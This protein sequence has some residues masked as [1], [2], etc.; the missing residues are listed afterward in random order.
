[1]TEFASSSI[2]TIFTASIATLWGDLTAVIPS[3]VIVGVGV[4]VL[5]AVI[6]FVIKA[7]RHIVNG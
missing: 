5:S 6:W 7:P 2:N 3:Y 1:M 4:A